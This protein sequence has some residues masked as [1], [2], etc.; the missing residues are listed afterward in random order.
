[1]K[2]TLYST[3]YETGYFSYTQ[4]LLSTVLSTLHV[5]TDPTITISEVNIFRSWEI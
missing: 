2:L 5:L 4:H 3:E 1:M